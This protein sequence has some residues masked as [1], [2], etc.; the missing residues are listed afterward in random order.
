LRERVEDIEALV[1][2]FIRKF[3]AAQHKVIQGID[4]AAL[5][6]LRQYRWPGNIRELENVIEHAFVLETAP[7]VR[8]SSLPETVRSLEARPVPLSDEVDGTPLIEEQLNYQEYKE[9]YEREFIIRAL[10]KF[11]GRINQ[12]SAQTNIPKKTL[13]R[14]IEKYGIKTEDFRK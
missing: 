2:H 1:S 7:V 9:R 13:L 14:K 11:N 8:E 5:Q 6:K 10:R 3:N 4:S 12:T